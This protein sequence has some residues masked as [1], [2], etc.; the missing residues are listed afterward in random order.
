MTGR[1]D[2]RDERWRPGADRVPAVVL[3]GTGYVAGELLRLLPSIRASRWRPCCPT[4]RGGSGSATLSRIS[5]AAIAELRFSRST[6]CRSGSRCWGRAA[7]R[8]RPSSPPRPTAPPRTAGRRVADGWGKGGV[9]V[10]WS[11]SRRISASRGRSIRGGLRPPARAPGRLRSSVRPARACRLAQAPDR[12]TSATLAASP[13]A[14]LLRRCRSWRWG[15]IEPRL[16]VVAVTGST[17][18]GRTPS[19]ST[20]HPARRSNL[21]A[22]DP[23]RT[24]TSPRCG[25]WPPP[26]PACRSR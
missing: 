17:G 24:A 20:H 12:R 25:R 8:R 22:Y 11:T 4:A 2:E 16:Q 13:T 26:R 3:G 15:W 9:A 18:A 21:F 5:P 1:G 7:R 19:P 10:R 14:A 23:L 6:S